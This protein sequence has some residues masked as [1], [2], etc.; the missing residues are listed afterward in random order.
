MKDLWGWGVFPA[1]A[2]VVLILGAG[3]FPADGA[4]GPP[5]GNAAAGKE[6]YARLCAVCHGPAGKGDGQALRGVPVRAKSFA[7][8]AAFREVSDRALFEA[9]QKGGAGTG[10]SPMM[11]PFG[12]QLKEGQ[13]WDLVAYIR[14][15][16]SPPR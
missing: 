2:L 5:Q 8:P 7:D 16:A 14:S 3:P 12:A 11:P 4:Q 1:T 9:I 15:L 10:K 6:T 13:I